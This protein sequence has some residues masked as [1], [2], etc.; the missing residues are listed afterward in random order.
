MFAKISA[1]F[2]ILPTVLVIVQM[3]EAFLDPSTP[4]EEKKRVALDILERV[5]VPQRYVNV[6][7]RLIDMV[8]SILHAL[9]VFDRQKGEPE[10]PVVEPERLVAPAASD[11]KFE[12]FLRSTHE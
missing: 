5:G 8:V 1:F 11:A 6:A 7:D 12:E 10:E 3:V 4:G 9:G 2:S